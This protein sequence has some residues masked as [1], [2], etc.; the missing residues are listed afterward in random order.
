MPPK[1]RASSPP[2]KP[3]AS[4]PPP[5]PLH[6]TLL[7]PMTTTEIGFISDN[8]SYSFVLYGKRTMQDACIEVNG[9]SFS[10]FCMKITIEGLEKQVYEYTTVNKQ[11]ISKFISTEKAIKKEVLLQR[12]L[13]TKFRKSGKRPI[14]PYVIHDC[15]LLSDEL[16][17]LF[18]EGR[19]KTLSV[20]VRHIIEAIQERSCRVHIFFMEYMD[21][22][23][24]QT[25]AQRITGTGISKWQSSDLRLKKAYHRMAAIL[26]CVTGLNIFPYDA[27]EPNV[28]LD[29][30][31]DDVRLIDLGNTFDFYN[32]EDGAEIVTLYRGYVKSV[33]PE[34]FPKDKLENFFIG[35]NNSRKT[36]ADSTVDLLE[37]RPNE[38][39]TVEDIHKNLMT[40][41]FVDFV[42]NG[43]IM[44]ELKPVESQVMATSYC[45]SRF[46]MESVYRVSF[47]NFKLFLDNFTL[48]QTDLETTYPLLNTV[49][50]FIIE[51]MD[52]RPKP[53][54]KGNCVIL[55]GGGGGSKPTFIKRY[56]SDILST[57]DKS[58]QRK[59]LT[60]SRRLYKQ[61]KYYTRKAMRSFKSKPSKHLDR[62]R[63]LYHV[64][65]IRPSRELSRKTGC[66]LKGLRQIVK[67]G[68]GAYYSS[69]SRP[70]Q[71]PQ[72][73]GNARLASANTGGNASLVD[74]H[75]LDKECEHR[76]PA[77][78]LAQKA[79]KISRHFFIIYTYNPTTTTRRC[80][81][82]NRNRNRNNILFQFKK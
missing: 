74:F 55:G 40:L 7:D 58:R 20:D 28:M 27:S 4:S 23:I 16:T 82:R 43:M 79:A 14:V 59:E 72:S 77:Y 69:G 22:R 53:T 52:N 67:K 56:L 9:I 6:E 45:K 21:N 42:K 63:S 60:K 18:V 41:A 32:K 36:I 17:Q 35:E 29:N 47:A 81:S 5:K 66:S 10:Q 24:Y 76:K 15:F 2:P 51:I 11:R 70:N 48:S 64:D 61:G 50:A 62:A 3:R 78:R 80:H 19:A 25:L 65:K 38:R 8:S 37:I 34:V 46:A 1:P 26:A 57:R 39:I 75:I 31:A 13:D 73:W 71:T 30:N 54:Q 33:K 68:E 49:K 12:E 44:N